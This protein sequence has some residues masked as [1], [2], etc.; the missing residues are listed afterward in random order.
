M[1]AETRNMRDLH[2]MAEVMRIGAAPREVMKTA[3]LAAVAVEAGTLGTGARED[4]GGT[5]M[6]PT[7]KC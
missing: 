4:A 1:A 3:E 5:L 7:L 6:V 2:Q